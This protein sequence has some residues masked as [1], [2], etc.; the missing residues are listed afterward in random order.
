LS[1]A[2]LLAA[3]AAAQRAPI[4][5]RRLALQRDVTELRLSPDGRSVAFVTDITGAL[6]AW[7]VSS[8]GGW[9]TQISALGEQVSELRYSPDGKKLI[10]QA[11]FGGDERPDLYLVDAYGGELDNLTVSTRAETSPRLSPDGRSVAFLADGPKPFQFQLYTMSLS[12]RAPVQLTQETVSVRSPVWS[13]DGRTIAVTRTGDDQ[14]GELMLVDPT[15]AGEPRVV[16]PPVSGGITIP[17][18]FSADSRLLLCL[19]R[20]E[21]GFLQLYLVD[22]GSGSGRFIGYD[23]WDVDQALFHPTAGIFFS[24]NEGGASALYRMRQPDSQPSQVLAARG[25][26]EA[27]DVD[28][29]GDLLGY[30]WS[31][32]SHAPDAWVLDLRTGLRTPVTRSMTG[33]VSSDALS[34]ARLFQYPSFDGRAATALFLPP[35]TRRLGTPPPA[36]VLVHGGPDWQIYDDWSAERQSFAEAGIAVIAPNFRGSTGYGRDWLELNQK[37]WGGGDRRDLIEAVKFLAKSGE[38]DGQRV[39]ITG[40]SFG[41]YMTLY[42]LARNKG[43]WAAGAEA[44]GMPDLIQ[45]YDLT[46]DRFGDWYATQMGTP[47]LDAKLFHERSA[48]TYLDDLKAPLLIFQGAND[49]NVPKSE[50]ELIYQKLKAQGRD[51]ELVVYPDEGHGFTKRKNRTDYYTRMVE[52]FAKRLAL[53]A[54]K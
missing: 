24:R 46:K 14:K 45:D 47:T 49:T 37:D 21:K 36:V 53:K 4:S 5:P 3:P 22:A 6:E 23:E 18:Q 40:G 26:I 9:P 51:V 41:G 43:E 33:G 44:Y 13:P 50:S 1:A 15:R 8:R 30:L 52:F 7:T 48:I 35:A 2:F 17:Q 32:S 42:A 38:I 19:S 54:A 20:N 29:S 28:D 16:N 25:R 31:D 12:S 10:F 34:R 39:G 27:F 11:D